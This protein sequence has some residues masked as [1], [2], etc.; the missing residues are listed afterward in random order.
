[1]IILNTLNGIFEKYENLVLTDYFTET[2]SSS[3]LRK[4]YGSEMI[5][6]RS[7]LQIL[8]FTNLLDF[9]TS[10][11]IILHLVHLIHTIFIIGS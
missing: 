2:Y 5:D 9:G 4:T 6:L 8:A 11:S 10:N 3:S 7:L 1:M